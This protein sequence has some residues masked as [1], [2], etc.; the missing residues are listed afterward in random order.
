MIFCAWFLSLTIMITRSI[1]VRARVSILFCFYGSVIF[2]CVD[3][4]HLLYPF[5]Y[6][7]AFEFFFSFYLLWL[8][9]LWIFVYRF[10]L[11]TCSQFFW[12]LV[13][14]WT[15]VVQLL[16]EKRKKQQEDKVGKERFQR[17]CLGFLFQPTS[18]LWEPTTKSFVAT[19]FLNSWVL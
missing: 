2:H 8:V 9:M 7:W 12:V 18:V 5:F 13:W 19:L 4:P 14:L 16:R 15:H 11:N 6:Q 1:H 17:L 10:C 3:R